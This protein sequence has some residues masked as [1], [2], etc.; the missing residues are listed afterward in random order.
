M[1]PSV[2]RDQPAG[3]QDAAD[4]RSNAR[5]ETLQELDRARRE[6]L[7]KDR[8]NPTR[9]GVMEGGLIFARVNGHH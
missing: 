2:P 5:S 1:K 9:G 7:H 4:R 8:R 6:L 3:A